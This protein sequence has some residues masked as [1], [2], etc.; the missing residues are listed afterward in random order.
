MSSDQI[1][2]LDGQVRADQPQ[3]RFD[4]LYTV[5]YALIDDAKTHY[6]LVKLYKGSHGSPDP[7]PVVL[8]YGEFFA[9]H[10]RGVLGYACYRRAGPGIN[11]YRVADLEEFDRLNPPARRSSDCQ[12]ASLRSRM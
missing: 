12:G 4:D 7:H 10:R 5:L 3:A 2:P 9:A 8:D 6:R 1:D 11:R